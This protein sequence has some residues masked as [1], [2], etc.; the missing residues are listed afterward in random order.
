L[1]S[2]DEYNSLVPKEIYIPKATDPQMT[3]YCPICDKFVARFEPWG[4][5]N[6]PDSQCPSCK[7][8]ERYR[9]LYLYLAEETDFFN[10]ENTVLDIGPL[11][12]FSQACLRYA[13]LKYVSIDLTS[14]R[15][16]AKMD[17]THL[18]FPNNCMD[19]IIC[20]HVLEHVP[21][22]TQAL[23]ELFR[24]AKPGGK[25]L[26]Q[27]PIDINRRETFYN[28]ST[29]QE[30]HGE[31]YGQHD[32]VRVYGNDF[33]KIVEAAGFQVERVRYVEQFSPEQ[34]TLMGLKDTY[35]L[36]LYRTC[37]DLF[38]ASKLSL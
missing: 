7:T 10:K 27:L 2:Y 16:V 26:L 25:I 34:Q 37:E 29:S 15:A 31:T 8:P 21:N 14:T 22:D 9:L 24:V 13:N 19:F 3:R 35:D 12:G 23:N 38:L 18:G 20:Y 33:Q 17:L 28:P 4:V 11:K 36:S 1:I 30:N 32:H 5:T 6:R